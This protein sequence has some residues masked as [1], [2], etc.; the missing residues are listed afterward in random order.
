MACVAAAGA[1]YFSSFEAFK[2]RL[3]D[4]VLATGVSGGLA[5]CAGYLSTYPLDVLK[6]AAMAVSTHR[7]WCVQKTSQITY[8]GAIVVKGV[9][10]STIPSIR[11]SEISD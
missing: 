7:W 5:G 10:R 9:A 11:Q 3:G 1:V 6:S 2:R 8:C 4:S